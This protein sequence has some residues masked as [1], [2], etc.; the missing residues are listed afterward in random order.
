MFKES[1]REYKESIKKLASRK[2]GKTPGDGGVGLNKKSGLI[3]H[4]L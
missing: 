3:S 2:A 1:Q 4:F